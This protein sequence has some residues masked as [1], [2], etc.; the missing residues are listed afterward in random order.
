M[1]KLSWILSLIACVALAFS[2]TGC[3]SIG[4][5]TTDGDAV[6]IEVSSSYDES[7]TL[8][9][10]M[11]KLEDEGELDFTIK[12]GM[13]TEI[14]GKENTLNSFWMLYTSDTEHANNAWGEY[15]HDGQ[16]FGSATL[17]ASELNVNPGCVYVWV[18]TTF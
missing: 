2:L 5:V 16:V 18:Y 13:V 14:G 4:T 9:D 12:N 3:K 1:K 11:Q 10:Y 17:G 7:A 6:I 8:L 15:E